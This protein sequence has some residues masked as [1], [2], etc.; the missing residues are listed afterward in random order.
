MA[1]TPGLHA[2]N[3]AD[4]WLGTLKNV[5]TGLPFAAC[6]V[7]LHVGNPGTDGLQN[8]AT[9]T[10]RK[11]ITWGT[12]SAGA[13]PISGTLSWT[14]WDSGP[15]TIT[16]MSVWTASTAG[17]YLYSFAITSKALANGDTLNL[18]AHTISLTPI[19]STA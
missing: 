2:A 15:E 11:Q 4:A 16:H 12:I 18:T 9:E 13:L 6:W 8:V 3:L 1:A 5:T 7:K 19:A 14:P 10:D 17:N